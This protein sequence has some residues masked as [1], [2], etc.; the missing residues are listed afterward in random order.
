MRTLHESMAVFCCVSALMTA[1]ACAQDPP[2]AS[3]CPDKADLTDIGVVLS[4]LDYMAGLET[5]KVSDDVMMID[6]AVSVRNGGGVDAG[7]TR[8]R[9]HV[10]IRA[11]GGAVA[12][13]HEDTM[14]VYSIAAGATE[15][16]L[17]TVMVSA[18]G[19]LL[20]PT[21]EVAGTAVF[22]VEA[23]VDGEISE[24]DES[25]NKAEVESPFSSEKVV[26]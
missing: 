21:G 16:S 8:L 26:E 15:E 12:Q 7:R 25:D 18:L 1:S 14:D 4:R 13:S 19:P 2:A 5:G 20:Q 22:R 17:V 3:Q 23:D 24:C 9:Y 6:F 11:P 10:D